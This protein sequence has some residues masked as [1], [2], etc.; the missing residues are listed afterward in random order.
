MNGLK[1]GAAN[2]EAMGFSKLNALCWWAKKTGVSYGTLSS[3][4]TEQQLQEIYD[5]YRQICEVRWHRQRELDE[6]CR[7]RKKKKKPPIEE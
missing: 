3:V 1:K 5:A 2:G 7:A 6:A 4:C